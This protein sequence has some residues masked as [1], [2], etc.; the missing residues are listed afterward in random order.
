MLLQTL[1]D[2]PITLEEFA[3]FSQFMF[4][5]MLNS[6]NFNLGSKVQTTT[7]ELIKLV[8]GDSKERINDKYSYADMKKILDK[9]LN[10]HKL[11]NDN[12]LLPMMNFMHP[13]PYMSM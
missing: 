13:Q 12:F 8:Q 2:K 9:I 4:A 1:D 11:M 5:T 10:S 6:S 3:V 7:Q